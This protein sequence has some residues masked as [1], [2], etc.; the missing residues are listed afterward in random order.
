M[1]A[2]IVYARTHHPDLLESIVVLERDDV[3]REGDELEVVG[4]NGD[5]TEHALFLE[6]AGDQS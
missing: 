2:S 3:F 5:I 1:C 6:Y 4:R